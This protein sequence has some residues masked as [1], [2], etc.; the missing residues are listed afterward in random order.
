MNLRIIYHQFALSTIN[1]QE[2]DF[3]ALN[4]GLKYGKL[5]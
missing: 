4:V 2:L 1:L 5:F 3:L